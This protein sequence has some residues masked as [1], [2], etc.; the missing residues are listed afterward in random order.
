MNLKRLKKLFRSSK[1]FLISTHV[2][3]DPDAICSELVMAM[4]LRSRGKTVHIINEDVVPPRYSFLPGSK[5]I[6]KFQRKK[7]ISYDVAIVL[8]CGDLDRIG[9]VQYCLQEGKPLI[10]IDHHI[11]NDGFGDLNFVLPEVS[12][13]AEIVYLM[14]KKLGARLTD[15]MAKNIYVGIMTDTGSFRYENTTAQTHRVVADLLKFKFSPTKLYQQIYETMP[16][17]DIQSFVKV[18][19]SFETHYQGRV[20]CVL[21]PKKISSQFSQS[22]DLRDTIFRFLRAIRGVEVLIILTAVGSKET[23]ANLRSTGSV[24]VAKVAHHFKGGGHRRASGCVIEG[25]L[26]EARKNAL[27]IIGKAL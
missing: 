25:S 20:V 7:K 19:N 14:L 11:T 2:N 27:K 5:T 16:L 15:S 9:K 10:N 26:K 21:L 18:I 17:K 3:P 4:Y 12:S 6:K 23:R 22:F 24:N 8:D 1:T 13:S